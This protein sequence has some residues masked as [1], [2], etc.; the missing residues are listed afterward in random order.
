MLW[1]LAVTQEDHP[2]QEAIDKLH[3]RFAEATVN[4]FDEHKHLMPGWETK[5]LTIV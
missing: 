4:L 2:S 3:T 5:K 1:M